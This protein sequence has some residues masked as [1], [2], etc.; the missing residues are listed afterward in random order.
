MSPLWLAGRTPARAAGAMSDHPLDGLPPTLPSSP[1]D[2]HAV[3][4]HRQDAIYRAVTQSARFTYTRLEAIM[5][6]VDQLSTALADLTASFQDFSADVTA[7]LQKNRET[8]AEM[9][10][11]LDA[12]LANDATDAAT[13]ADLRAQLANMAAGTDAAL[14]KI[15]ALNEA[16]KQADVAVDRPRTA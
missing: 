15:V 7:A 5:A 3:L 6:T 16:V 2:P 10:R 11:T 8:Q 1:L 12:A 4:A 13:I 9:Q 14:G